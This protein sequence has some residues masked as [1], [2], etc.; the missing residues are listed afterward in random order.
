MQNFALLGLILLAMLIPVAAIYALGM[1]L[2]G[3]N[4]LDFPML[5]FYIVI[6]TPHIVVALA[7]AEVVIVVAAAYLI[8]HTQAGRFAAEWLR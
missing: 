2:R 3:V 7:V 5:D 1:A 6:A 8:G 4:S